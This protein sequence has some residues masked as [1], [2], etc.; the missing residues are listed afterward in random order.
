MT[1]RIY[2]PPKPFLVITLRGVVSITPRRALIQACK[3]D[4]GNK[5]PD[6]TF[7]IEGYTPE[8]VRRLLRAAYPASL[9]L[10]DG[11]KPSMKGAN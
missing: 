11:R 1:Q 3:D 9:K 8:M 5:L 6:G 7:V 4:A 10:I 2:Q